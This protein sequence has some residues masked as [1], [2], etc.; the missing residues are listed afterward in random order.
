MWGSLRDPS[1]C[2]QDLPAQGLDVPAGGEFPAPAVHDVQLLATVVVIPGVGISSEDVLEV[3]LGWLIPELSF[4]HGHF[5]IIDPLLTRP[6]T[7][8]GPSLDDCSRHSLTC[9]T[10]LMISQHSEA[11]WR[12]LGCTGH[13][14]LLPPCGRGRL[15]R[16]PCPLVVATTV[17]AA[18]CGFSYLRFFFFLLPSWETAP[19]PPI[20]STPVCGTKCHARPSAALAH[21]SARVKRVEIVSTSC[22]AY[23]SN[24]FSSHT[25]WRKAM[26]IEAS[27]IR[28]MVPRT[29]VKQAMNVRRVS[30]GSCLTV[31]RWASTPCCW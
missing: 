24:I 3:P 2:R 5:V 26:M 30:P 25:P 22:V 31:W 28:G 21:L 9:F 4:S 17:G 13:E 1:S 15:L 10:S 12:A 14:L 19:V 18:N 23:F 16:S 7:R 29:L 11:L 8:R 6:A 20:W 27:D